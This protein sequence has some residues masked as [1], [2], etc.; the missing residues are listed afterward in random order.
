MGDSI[1]L[2]ELP[3]SDYIST[4]QISYEELVI[5][6]EDDVDDDEGVYVLEGHLSCLFGHEDYRGRSLRSISCTSIE[7]HVTDSE[8]GCTS[9]STLPVDTLHMDQFLPSNHELYKM[10]SISANNLF[11][12]EMPD[13]LF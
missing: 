3:I 2:C 10:G 11:G 12:P 5:Q 7:S 13:L 8:D 9:L 4:Q 6:R 1:N